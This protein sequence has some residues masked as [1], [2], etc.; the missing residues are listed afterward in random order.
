MEDSE[1]DEVQSL[2]PSPI[3]M[4]DLVSESEA[5]S[6]EVEIL[7]TPPVP[8]VD[9]VSKEKEEVAHPMTPFS[10]GVVSMDISEDIEDKLEMLKES[11]TLT[12]PG[13]SPER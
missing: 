9:L 5:A 2:K 6:E 3:P 13:K 12:C 11:D 4:V 8:V 10:E 7:E 1:E